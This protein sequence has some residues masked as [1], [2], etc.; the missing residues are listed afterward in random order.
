MSAYYAAPGGAPS[1]ATEQEQLA[2]VLVAFGGSAPQSRVTVLFRLLLVI[3]HAIVLYALGIAAEVVAIIG[4]FAALFTGRLPDFAADYLTGYLRWQTR[5]FGYENLLTDVYPPFTLE[6]ADYPIR[7]AVRPGRL[8]RLA[9][10]F[11]FFLLIPAMVVQAV[12]TFG[13]YTIGLF[14][15]WLIMLISGRMPDALY[16]A[17]AA[18]LRYQTRISGFLY[19]LT[20]TY[21]WGLYGDAVAAGTV[22][23]QAGYGA[24]ETPGEGGP[25]GYGYGQQAG[26]GQQP[27][28]E[29]QPE[30]GQPEG[31]Q[32][33]AGQ[34]EAGQP[35]A[36]PQAAPKD[37]V[38]YGTE[39]EHGPQPAPEDQVVYGTRQ[40]GE[41]QPGSGDQPGF[42][43]EPGSGQLPA[44][45]AYAQPEYEV[46]AAGAYGAATAGPA[47]AAW[48]LVLSAAAKRLVTTFIALGVLFIVG[49]VLILAFA[50]SNVVTAAEANHQLRTDVIPAANAIN[51]YP[52][53]VQQCGNSLPC[54]TNLDRSVAGALNTFAARV[55]GIDMPS[56]QASAQAATLAGSVTHVASIF[57]QLGGATSVTQYENIANASGLQQAVIQMNQ[58]Y[59]NLG[60]TLSKG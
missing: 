25:Q 19:M 26:Y 28:R 54:V 57:S 10:L 3:P 14:V 38:V 4:W 60:N 1:V 58:D 24:S 9:V 33:E 35:E 11:R 50:T 18:I 8:N 42:G 55:R 46:P 37:Q 30:G 36:G 41:P 40:E 45:G 2:P 32:P 21:P 49:L 5:V 27:Q 7:V 29:G 53:N 56:D 44:Y 23:F 39:P 16:Q 17:L 47:M 59:I 43:P 48:L 20:S 15:T 22:E 34:P 6:D 12:V 52:A 31:G 13:A 51:N